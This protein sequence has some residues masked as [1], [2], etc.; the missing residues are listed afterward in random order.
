MNDVQSPVDALPDNLTA[1]YVLPQLKNVIVPPPDLRPIVEK[2]A[3]YVAKHGTAFEAVILSKQQ[4]DRRFDFLHP[5]NAY[6]SF[7]KSKLVQ[8]LL[9]PE[10]Q[11]RL[12]KLQ[13]EQE[14]ERQALAQLEAEHAAADAAEEAAA[15]KQV[16]FSFRERLKLDIARSC[17]A[18]VIPTS[19]AEL[20]PAYASVLP[21]SYG[22]SPLDRDIIRLT[23]RYVASQG[24]AFLNGL[25]TREARNPSFDFM[26]SS[27]PFY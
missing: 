19:A 9:P 12:A 18:H 16:V 20:D 27:H 7:Y 26:R 22:V 1:E 3:A 11:D 21:A 2:T 15:P 17:Q 23:A 6:H 25:I 10:E 5:D 13:E 8:L 14:A 4:N 24:K